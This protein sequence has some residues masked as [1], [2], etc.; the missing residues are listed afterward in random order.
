MLSSNLIVM[1]VYG[2]MVESNTELFQCYASI[3][4]NTVRLGLVASVGRDMNKS[5][6]FC[7]SMKFSMKG[8]WK[9][10]EETFYVNES[11]L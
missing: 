11:L 1:V 4:S 3:D 2:I 9:K 7:V 8:C 5:L 6:A 10:V